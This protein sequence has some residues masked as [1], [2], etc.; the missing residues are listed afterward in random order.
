M[1]DLSLEE[2]YGRTKLE[3]LVQSIDT[4]T[5]FDDLNKITFSNIAPVGPNHD[6]YWFNSDDGGHLFKADNRQGIWE[7]I[8]GQIGVLADN[9]EDVFIWSK[10][11]HISREH[12][13]G[14]N[15][16]KYFRGMSRPRIYVDITNRMDDPQLKRMLDASSFNELDCRTTRDKLNQLISR[17][18]FHK[19]AEAIA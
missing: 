18:T 3:C 7:P 17:I 8:Q 14:G 5:Y 15:D 19:R 9:Q 1:G 4:H 10:R 6:D 2:E 12:Y 16:I 11:Y 13:Y